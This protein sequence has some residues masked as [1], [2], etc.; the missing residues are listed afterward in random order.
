M[1]VLVII[2]SEQH[3]SEHIDNII[4]LNNYLRNMQVDYCAISSN[5]DFHVYE[6]IIKLKFKFKSPKKQFSKICDFISEHRGELQYDWYIKFR[7][8]IKLLE[9]INFD[10]LL[11][12][13]INARA[14][15]YIG[16]KKIKYGMSVNGEGPWKNIGDCQYDINTMKIILDDIFYIFHRKIINKGGFKPIT[17]DGRQDE[18]FH[19]ETWRRRSIHLNIIGIHLEF[20]K[21]NTKSGDLNMSSL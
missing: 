16:P 19:T 8:E 15:L 12:N 6:N 17:F 20:T 13:A 9:P 7:P 3:N 18:Y 10:K 1:K 11:D 2:S 21:N 4:I 14:R 5:D